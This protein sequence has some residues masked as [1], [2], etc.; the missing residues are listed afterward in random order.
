MWNDN[1]LHIGNIK[2]GPVHSH[3]ARADIS[4]FIGD[5]TAWGQG[6]GGEAVQLMTDI[7]FKQLSVRKLRALA[8]EAN[9]ASQ[10]VLEK[11]GYHLEATFKDEERRD[12]GA[13]WE[14]VKC[15]VKFSH[16][17]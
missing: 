16:L 15:F 9:L 17:K 1:R 14:D 8:R 10:R 2:V 6:F 4:Y 7:A 12:P 13:N 5:R 11:A 3:Y